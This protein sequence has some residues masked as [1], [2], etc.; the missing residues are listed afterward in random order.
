MIKRKNTKV[1]SVHTHSFSIIVITL[2]KGQ[3]CC[4]IVFLSP[5]CYYLFLLLSVLSLLTYRFFPLQTPTCCAWF[6]AN[7]LLHRVK[8]YIVSDAAMWS[9]KLNRDTAVVSHSWPGF[10]VWGVNIY[11]KILCRLHVC[12]FILCCTVSD[13]HMWLVCTCLVECVT[14]AA[15]R[16]G[17]TLQLT[18][19]ERLT[20]IHT[21]RH[22]PRSKTLFFVS[23]LNEN[24][25]S[26]QTQ[27]VSV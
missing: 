21:Y 7:I 18:L 20:D 6:H 2:N 15:T 3:F 22:E 19:L 14:G 11:S 5:C 1:V 17:S 24:G 25:G 26:V 4:P 8:G 23:L 10:N 16:T 27:S 9:F 12:M 13:L